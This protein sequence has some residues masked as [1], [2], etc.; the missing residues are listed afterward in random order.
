VIPLQ[1]DIRIHCLDLYPLR[2]KG[3]RFAGHRG[4]PP[5]LCQ[6]RA[7][8][9]GIDPLPGPGRNGGIGFSIGNKGYVGGGF[10]GNEVTRKGFYEFDP[11]APPGNQW[12]QIQD[13]PL[14]IA[15]LPLSVMTLGSRAYLVFG[16][17][18]DFDTWEFDPARTNPW[19]QVSTLTVDGIQAFVS[20]SFAIYNLGY[21]IL[22]REA[23]NFW[24]YVPEL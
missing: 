7:R 4:A 14:P 18:H 1:S 13:L 23:D 9:P 8:S 5:D 6:H 17:L 11:S 12:K 2:P 10:T 24:M 21:I 3:S 22:E 15:F 19:K 20:S 16:F